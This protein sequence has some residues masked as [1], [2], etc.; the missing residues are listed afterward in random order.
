MCNK[1]KTL[2]IKKKMNI[3]KSS[4][5]KDVNFHPKKAH[6]KLKLAGFE[7]EKTPKYFW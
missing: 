6:L 3:F 5:K 1:K 4:L 7:S 2:R